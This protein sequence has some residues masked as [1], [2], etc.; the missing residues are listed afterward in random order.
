MVSEADRIVRRRA[1]ANEF[2]ATPEV[3]TFPRTHMIA[4]RFQ[5]SRAS[6]ASWVFPTLVGLAGVALVVFGW[7]IPL[8]FKSLPV[9][10]L[11][12]A[13]R[14]SAGLDDV[15]LDR[16]DAGRP[17]PARILADAA[18]AVKLPEA[19][20][21][22]E[23]VGRYLETNPDLAVWGEANPYLTNA[24]TTTGVVTA[25]S[26]Q[27]GIVRQIL[28]TRARA[29]LRTFLGRSRNATVQS[30]L[31][32][33]ELQTW[34]QFLPVFSSGGAPL[35][36]TILLTALLVQ[37]DEFG[38]GA[39]R[40]LRAL[41]EKTVQTGQAAELE[42]FFLDVLSLGR[43]YDWSQLAAITRDAGSL[44]SIA[45]IRH[46]H[47]V[48]PEEIRTIVAAVLVSRKP[49]AVADYVMRYGP[50]GSEAVA[51]A[52][53]HGTG[54]LDLLLRQQLPPDG[55]MVLPPPAGESALSRV[56]VDPLVR[57][58]L[59]SHTVA[60]AAKFGAYLL[61]GLLLFLVAERLTALHRLELSARFTVLA[62]AVGATVA[63]LFLVVINEP[64]LAFGSSASGYELRLVVPVLG[65]ASLDTM[66]ESS[67][68]LPIDVATMVSISFFF[69]LQVLVYLICLFK[70][71]EIER[72]D[73]P[74]DVKLRM[75]ENEDNLFDSGL[76]VGIAGTSAALVLQVL[77]V[78]QANLLAAYSSNLFGIMCVALIKIRHVRP[79]K[80]RLL[81]R[82]AR[83]REAA[84]AR[85]G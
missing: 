4:D 63:C 14:G 69:M 48:A 37:S 29:E 74:E 61:G 68:A 20:R 43:R 47:Q 67:N 38:S 84:T 13:G 57:F 85:V 71:K 32:T 35:E 8:Q 17:G 33:A 7:L 75:A 21:L 36:A 27:V 2:V 76:Y 58:A 56:A 19:E 51:Y 64:F 78:I 81:L 77:G 5:A 45:K 65:S 66:N 60:V 73:V 15:A 39:A 16:L 3:V 46:L 30:L 25:P 23:R 54:S 34:K 83:A 49:D 28:P 59:R 10:I 1:S 12:E 18:V 79:F 9:S 55:E 82:I 62:R 70:L 31:A 42:L 40:E 24:L 26:E 53:H 72:H 22:V 50:L 52:M 44:E 11:A 41:A 80:N 6:A